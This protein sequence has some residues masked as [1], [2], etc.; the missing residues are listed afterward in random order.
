MQITPKIHQLKIDFEIPV[1]PVQK[2]ARF[3][4]VFLIFGK[5]ITLID[6]GVHG[7]KDNIFKYIES[8]N[9]KIADIETIILSH[10]HPD[11]IG[12]AAEIKD[13]T[14]CKVLAHPD[15]ENWLRDI[16]LQNTERPVPGFFNLVN[17]SVILDGYLHDG[18]LFKADDDLTLKIIHAPGHSKGSLNINFVEDKVLYT[19]DSIPL[20]GDIPNYDNYFNLLR[21]LENIRNYPDVDTILSSWIGPLANNDEINAVL[22]EGETY[23]RHIDKIALLNY[24]ETENEPYSQCRETIKQ[25]KLPEFLVNAVTDKAF[26]SHLNKNK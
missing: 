7:S 12:N 17:R 18:Q 2:L 10:S 23:I 3:V 26:R 19:A 4:N 15:E 24:Q 13:L 14:G 9:R 5:K 1:S 8:Q 6:T 11:H 20:K 16:D 25:L 22:K 21:S